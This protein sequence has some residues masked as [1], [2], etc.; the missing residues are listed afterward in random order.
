MK[1]TTFQVVS[2][3]KRKHSPF[4]GKNFVRSCAESKKKQCFRFTAT[5]TL[6]TM[7]NEVFWA[8]F[9]ENVVIKKSVER[10]RIFG[11]KIRVLTK[12][13]AFGAQT[14]ACSLNYSF[15][16]GLVGKIDESFQRKVLGT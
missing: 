1:V 6:D 16:G 7:R 5:V 11:Q 4:S 12:S 8:I 13:K 14:N 2:V 15:H 3:E 10:N 9:G